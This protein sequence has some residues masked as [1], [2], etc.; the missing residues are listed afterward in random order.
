MM[1]KLLYAG[2]AGLRRPAVFCRDE[3]CV[4]AVANGC[5]GGGGRFGAAVARECSGL[6][7]GDEAGLRQS[8]IGPSCRRQRAFWVPVLATHGAWLIY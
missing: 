1:E 2:T 6:G 3:V 5:G 8:E 7:S 4:C